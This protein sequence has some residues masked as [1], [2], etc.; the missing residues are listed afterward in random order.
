MAYAVIPPYDDEQIIAGQATCG[1]EIIEAFPKWNP[2][3][4][5]RHPAAGL[6][7]GIATRGQT[8]PRPQ[9]RRSSGRA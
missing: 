2:A 4:I 6:L 3:L 1:L 5:A 8:V 9:T 7:S